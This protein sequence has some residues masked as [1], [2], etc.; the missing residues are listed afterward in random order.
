MKKLSLITFGVIAFFAVV[1]FSTS[2]KTTSNEPLKIV[3][4]AGHGG[5]D[6]GTTDESILE[7]NITLKLLQKIK[8]LHNTKDFELIFTR[9]NDEFISLEERVKIANKN[10]ADFV[11]SLHVNASNNKNDNG[12]EAYTKTNN[13]EQKTISFVSSLVTELS[14]NNSP[15]QKTE[16]RKANFKILR[17]SKAPA[18]LLE[19]GFISNPQNKAY[20][21]SEKGQEEVAEAILKSLKKMK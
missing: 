12:I 6:L 19:L 8:K 16:M 18:V 7:K 5:K 10:N 2:K 20:I 9:E 17:D 3:I 4:D 13:T 11:I 21:T 14:F 15:L 1:A